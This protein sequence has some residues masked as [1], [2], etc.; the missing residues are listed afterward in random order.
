MFVRHERSRSNDETISSPCHRHVVFGVESNFVASDRTFPE[1]NRNARSSASRLDSTALLH[2]FVSD[3]S[4]RSATFSAVDFGFDRFDCFSLRG[5]VEKFDDQRRS[6][7]V[8]ERRFASAVA[9][10]QP[11][12]GIRST[13]TDS[14]LA[15][16]SVAADL[17]S[18]GDERR[19]SVQRTDSN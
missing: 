7:A 13:P 11:D 12:V 6:F 17:R 16:R 15:E 19:I 10:R 18:I 5:D 2:F 3:Q 4:V 8:D 1:E 9:G 14:F